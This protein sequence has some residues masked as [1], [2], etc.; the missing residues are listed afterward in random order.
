MTFEEIKTSLGDQWVAYYDGL[1]Q[2]EAFGIACESA[3]GQTK[4]VWYTGT[5]EPVPELASKLITE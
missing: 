2:E 3:C 5:A 1:T 4:G